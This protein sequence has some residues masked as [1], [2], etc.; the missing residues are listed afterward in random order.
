MF[1]GSCPVLDSP[2]KS[3]PEGT[4][5]VQEVI[6][7]S[8]AE[9]GRDGETGKGRKPM[10]VTVGDGGWSCWRPTGN[11]WTHFTTVPLRGR[12]SLGYSSPNLP[13]PLLRVTVV[14]GAGGG[15]VEHTPAAQRKCS[16]GQAVPR[17]EV[18]PVQQ[19]VS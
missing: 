13:T 16:E 1:L 7:E 18:S 4:I 15:D 3:A 10:Q 19:I 17:W 5:W 12:G 11:L 9:W 8:R 6:L 2:P 14:S